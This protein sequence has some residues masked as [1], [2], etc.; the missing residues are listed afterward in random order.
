MSVR[1][2]LPIKRL[3]QDLLE[4]VKKELGFNQRQSTYFNIVTLRDIYF[5]R[6]GDKGLPIEEAYYEWASNGQPIEDFFTSK[7]YERLLKE[8]AEILADF[9]RK[10][11][12]KSR[13]QE[14]K[15]TAH[16][17]IAEIVFRQAFRSYKRGDVVDSMVSMFRD[18]YTRLLK[19]GLSEN[20][21]LNGRL[22]ADGTKEYGANAIFDAIY[23]KIYNER[24]KLI[25]YQ[26]LLGDKSNFSEVAGVAA[27]DEE[28]FERARAEVLNMCTPVQD[29]VYKTL[30]RPGIKSYMTDKEKLEYVAEVY[31]DMLN[32]WSSVV[33]H[34]KRD[35][36]VN[37]GIIIGVG[38]D[39]GYAKETT[40]GGENDLEESF[41]QEDTRLCV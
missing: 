27:E 29:N 26:S 33:V 9:R 41:D 8:S 7:D 20:V 4:K 2:S 14:R 13:A 5:D 16:T 38:E 22:K 3:D 6:N 36:A 12:N 10:E 17:L 39:Y 21:V 35:I 18:F 40:E 31:T 11:L 28:F 37:D 24:A 23:D 30:V 1:C 34:A 15:Y 32:N 19:T 25:Y